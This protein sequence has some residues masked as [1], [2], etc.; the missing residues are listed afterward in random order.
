MTTTH[1]LIGPMIGG[2]DW[3]I[4]VQLTDQ[5]RQ[6]YNIDDITVKWLLHNPRGQIVEHEAIITTLNAAQ[7]RISI[8]IP[9]T[10]TTKFTDGVYTDYVRIICNG[11]T[12]TL[13]MG[14]ISVMRDPWT[15]E[16][17]PSAVIGR[18][19]AEIVVLLDHKERIQR[20]PAAAAAN[21]DG[22]IVAWERVVG[23]KK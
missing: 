5:D 1:R 3:Q 14:N 8:W 23:L 9:A 12:S 18:S 22:A 21:D 11:I 2:D 4:N 6:P 7:G 10:E 17:A 13:L 16:I 15:A 19:T 20:R